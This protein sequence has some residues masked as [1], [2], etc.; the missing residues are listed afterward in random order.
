MSGGQNTW[1]CQFL[2]ELRRQGIQSQVLCFTPGKK[3]EL[4]TVRSLRQAGV[5]CS[6]LSQPD[7]VYTEQQTTWILERLATDRPDVFVSNM[8]IPAAYYAG[9]WLREAGIPTVGVCHGG[10]MSHL[11]AGLLDQFVLGSDAYR[12]SAFVT[13]SDYLEQDVLKR[14]PKNILVRRIP[15]GLP[16]PRDVAKRRDGRLRLAYVGQLVE[17]RKRI[18][19]LTRAFCRAVREIEGTEAFIYG[20]GPDRQRVEQILRSEGNGLPVYLVGFVENDQLRKDLQTCHAVVLLSDHEG[21]GLALLEGMACGVVP[22][23][24]QAASG[25]TE[26]VIDNVTGLLSPDRSDGFIAAVRRLREYPGLWERLSRS[27]R[28]QVQTEYSEETCADRWQELFRKLLD[29]SGSQK[30][31]RIPRRLHLPP[32]HPD[33]AEMDRRI[34]PPHDRAI[35]RVRAFLSYIHCDSTG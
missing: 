15:Y 31:L 10:G 20:D 29:S 24:L 8:V 33:L 27:A 9:R 28:A 35:A 3:E 1:L 13:I 7:H 17:E 32:V 19:E 12:V 30:P 25:L 34:P 26:F 16:V 4:P 18:S 2:P 21:L 6:T 14:N 23:G 5:P 22:I 11:F